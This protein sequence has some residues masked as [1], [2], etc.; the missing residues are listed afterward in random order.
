MNWRL[1]AAVLVTAGLFPLS[2]CTS[3]SQ[4]Q[5]KEPEKVIDASFAAFAKGHDAVT[6]WHEGLAL[7][8]FTYEVQDRLLRSDKRP[9]AFKGDLQDIKRNAGK[10][11][12]LLK[13]SLNDLYLVLEADPEQVRQIV[14]GR[15]AIFSELAVIA[16]VRGVDRLA[17]TVKADGDPE[18]GARVSLDSPSSTEVI[19]RCIALKVLTE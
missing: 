6:D 2:S 7:F 18:I 3:R 1:F 19:G 10:Y 4:E 17:F 14:S 9:I 11:Q 15:D 12:L 8:A 16:E 5:S 13:D